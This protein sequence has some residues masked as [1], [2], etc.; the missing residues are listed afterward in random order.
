MWE[1]KKETDEQVKQLQAALEEAG[2]A[3]VSHFY[4][5]SYVTGILIGGY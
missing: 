5:I 3:A 4:I 2:T 1:L